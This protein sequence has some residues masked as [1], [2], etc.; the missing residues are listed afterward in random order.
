MLK[1]WLLSPSRD[2]TAHDKSMVEGDMTDGGN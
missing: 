1:I 2:I